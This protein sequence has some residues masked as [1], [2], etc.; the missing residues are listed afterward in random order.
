MATA[1][2][3]PLFTTQASSSNGGRS[4]GNVK[5]ADGVIDLALVVPKEMGGPG[6]H[7]ANPE[8]LFAAGYAS[9]FEGALRMVAGLD[10]IKLG[11]ATTV[12]A[13]VTFGKTGDGGF[14]IQAA[15]EV[16]ADGV[17]HAKAE[18]LVAK[19]HQACPYSKATSG[20]IVVDIKTV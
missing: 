17:D 12:T 7:G 11:P 14:G 16:H 4:G 13:K 15:L 1:L 8:V 10:K 5:S 18:E 9:C 19:A 6:G 2:E 20:N 3:T